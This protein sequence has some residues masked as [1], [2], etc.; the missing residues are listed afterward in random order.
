MRVR[1]ER[2]SRRSRSITEPFPCVRD[3]APD[4]L[5]RTAGD[6]VPPFDDP[7]PHKR[8]WHRR[9]GH[10]RIRANG[11]PVSPARLAAVAAAGPV[12]GPGS[13]DLSIFPLPSKRKLVD[14]QDRIRYRGTVWVR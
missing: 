1:A 8:N 3:V 9:A 14:R 13:A 5:C 7:L 11:E 4:P 10:E 12:N 6:A 2:A